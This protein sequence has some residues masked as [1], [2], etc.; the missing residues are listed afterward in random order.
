M[1][2]YSKR[3]VLNSAILTG[4]HCR[5]IL[6][7]KFEV[8]GIFSRDTLRILSTASATPSNT[9]QYYQG[10]FPLHPHH[11]NA[12]T[13]HLTS[14][15]TVINSND[16]LSHS[17]VTCTPPVCSFNFSTP[18][19]TW[20]SFDQ[21]RRAFLEKRVAF[22]SDS[23]RVSGERNWWPRFGFWHSR[24]SYWWDKDS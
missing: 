5:S 6:R 8:S 2:Y 17:F 10:S 13:N 24:S 23:S 14:L 1:Y 3:L 11:P 7:P 18:P 15:I 16:A 12:I 20:F 19:I 22:C 4:K 9:T 21:N